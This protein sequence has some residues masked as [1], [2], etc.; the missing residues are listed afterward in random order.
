MHGLGVN[1]FFERSLSFCEQLT[2]EIFENC[3][4]CMLASDAFVYADPD[5]LSQVR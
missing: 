3:W 2:R 5:Q 1:P 4:L